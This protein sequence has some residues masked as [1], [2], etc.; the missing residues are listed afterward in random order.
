MNIVEASGEVPFV[1]DRVLPDRRCQEVGVCPVSARGEGDPLTGILRAIR[2]RSD[3][4]FREGRH[5]IH[6]S[7]DVSVNATATLSVNLQ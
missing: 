5:P 2:E 3:A 7:R 1:A 6:C 4:K